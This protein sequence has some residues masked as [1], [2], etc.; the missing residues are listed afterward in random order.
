MPA[1]RSVRL[2]T[3]LLFLGIVQLTPIAL[4][5]ISKTADF[6]P[7]QLAQAEVAALYLAAHKDLGKTSETESPSVS[8]QTTVQ[9]SSSAA[10][11]A[12]APIKK[13]TD[14]RKTLRSPS[15]TSKAASKT[16]STPTKTNLPRTPA[17]TPAKTPTTAPSNASPVA[18]GAKKSEAAPRRRKR[19]SPSPSP[20]EKA[21]LPEILVD[22]ATG[23]PL[24]GWCNGSSITQEH[25]QY[26]IDRIKQTPATEEPYPHLYIN[27]I[28]H[29]EVYACIMTSLPESN[30]MYQP[31]FAAGSAGAER[32][33][34]QIMEEDVVGPAVASRPKGTS[35]RKDGKRQFEF[36][37]QDSTDVNVPFWT[38]FAKEFGSVPVKLAYMSAMKRTLLKRSVDALKPETARKLHWNMALS[39][40]IT[41]YSIGPHTDSYGKWVTV[42]YYLPK[43]YS[44]P[45]ESGTCVMRSKSGMMQ[46]QGSPWENWT[47]TDFEVAEQAHFVPNSV[48][49]FASC[50]SS[51]H[52][53]PQISTQFTRDTIQAF[54]HSPRGQLKDVGKTECPK[55][56]TAT[57]N[58]D[59]T[60]AD[61]LN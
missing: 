52:A 28:F 33:S 51:W 4:G 44:A 6:T 21:P 57:L 22:A 35:S 45:R 58:T 9:P 50:F 39:R 10:S 34:L 12:S 42:L 26:T 61:I 20:S 7:Q 23:P 19:R 27:G 37:P 1:V 41:G 30:K 32:Y 13:S 38:K 24:P 18:A 54:I 31:L 29:P 55:P 59:N 16:P 11:T 8:D 2:L 46:G 36:L 15:V 48:F 49:V 40:D 47:N 60:D 43:D 14:S 5:Q 3:R 25:V 17:K 56:H 53:V